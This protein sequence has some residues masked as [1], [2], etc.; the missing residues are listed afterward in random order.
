MLGSRMHFNSWGRVGVNV[1]I[2]LSRFYHNWNGFSV[3]KPHLLFIDIHHFN[4]TVVKLD[5]QISIENCGISSFW[6]EQSRV[7]FI[8]FN[9]ALEGVS[10]YESDQLHPTFLWSES[11]TQLPYM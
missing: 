4:R 9:L 10:D 7:E 2:G 11:E 6:T 5:D 8:D 3:A 1:R